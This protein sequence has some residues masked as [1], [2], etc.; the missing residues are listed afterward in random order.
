MTDERG[1]HENSHGIYGSRVPPQAVCN[2]GDRVGVRDG[3]AG[4]RA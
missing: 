3:G 4:G 2:S 1:D